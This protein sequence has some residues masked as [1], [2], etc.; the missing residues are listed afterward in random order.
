MNCDFFITN[1][2]YTFYFIEAT[3]ALIASR[4]LLALSPSRRSVGV[5]IYDDSYY[6][7]AHAH[8]IGRNI[9]RSVHWV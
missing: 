8:D 6:Q 9:A 5:V 3:N 4:S 2:R 7:R 1:P